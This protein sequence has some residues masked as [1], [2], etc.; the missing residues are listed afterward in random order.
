V[1]VRERERE[2]ERERDLQDIA[3]QILVRK[4][5]HQTIEDSL[6]RT[7]TRVVDEIVTHAQRNVLRRCIAACHQL[8]NREDEER[9]QRK[10]T[11]SY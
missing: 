4:I 9:R 7:E 1:R 10:F 8:L 5:K 6:L 3:L 11:L 2:R